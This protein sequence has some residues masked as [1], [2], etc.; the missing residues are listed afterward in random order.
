MFAAITARVS[1][2]NV[3]IGIYALVSFAAVAAIVMAPGTIG[4]HW[5]WMIPSDP[6]EL[7]RFALTDGS[8]WQDYD[9]GSY[10]TYRYA[11]VLTSLLFGLP[12]YLG[13]DGGFVTKSLVASGVFVSA[14]GMRYLLL[15]LTRD[16]ADERDGALA[17]LGGLL[18]A[19]APYAYNQIVAGDQSALIADALSPIAIALAVRCIAPRENRWLAF[20]LTAS[21]LLGII[22]ASVQVFVFTLAVMWAV[23]LAIGWS[24]LTVVRLGVLTAVSIALCAFWLLPAF[25]AGGAVH[26]VVQTSP[27]D[28]AIATFGQFSNPLLTLTM[29]AFPGDFYLRAIAQG[30]PLYFAAFVLLLALSVAAIAIRRTPLSIV[31]GVLFLVTA[32]VPLGGNAFIGPAI[33]AVFRALLPYSLFLRTPQHLMFVMALV[34]P[35]M[36]YLAARVVAPKYYTVSLVAGL[37]VVAAY[38]Q[39]FFLHSNYFGLIGPFGESNG[40]RATVARAAESDG[41]SYRTLFVPNSPSFYFHPGIFDYFFE[42]SDDPQVR[43]LPGMSLGAG[44]KWTPYDRTQHLVKALDELVPDGADSQTQAMLLKIAGIQQIVVHHIGTPTAGVRLATNNQQPYLESALRATRLATLEGAYDDRSIWRLGRAVPRVYAPDCVF[45]VP[46]QADPYD[47]LALAPAAASCARPVTLATTV[48]SERS[49]EIISPESFR[50]NRSPGVPF[51]L[52]PSNV[53]IESLDGG[54]AFSAVVPSRTQDVEIFELPRKP[55][56]ATGVSLRMYSSAPRRVYV[57]LYSPDEL[58]FLQATVD[59]SGPVQDVALNFRDFGHV[60][61]PDVRTFRY[62]RLA[63]INM[64]GHD[65]RMYVGDARWL[66]HSVRSAVPP[67]LTVS[68]NRWDGFYFGGNRDRVVYQPTGSPVPVFATAS[69]VRTGTYDVVAR[70]Q[71]AKRALSLR[72]V[73]DGRATRC[74][75]T[76]GRADETERLVRLARL[77]MSRGRHTIALAFCNNP[78]VSTTASGVQALIIAAA[79]FAPPAFRSGGTV[80]VASTAPGT[81]RLNVGSNVIVFT[82]SFDDRWTATQNGAALARVMANGYANAW[83]VPDPSAGD[84]VLQFWPQRSFEFGIAVSLGL[85]AACLVIIALTLLEFRPARAPAPVTEH[86]TQA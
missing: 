57:Q 44:Q 84:V 55:A 61:R 68:G 35:M 8:A 69:I 60:G 33:I 48:P 77:P 63:S 83:R 74:S 82:D 79:S 78:L 40:E 54:H 64:Q 11:T 70:V 15:S 45:G 23:C 42:G 30:A 85:A 24:R 21:L 58:N 46:P 62:V 16:D 26:T 10:V 50:I 37:F 1:R 75:P 81:M 3:A 47:V 4:H 22:V 31:L 65:V 34:V 41:D 56:A 86:A 66:Y 28:T 18:Y 49:E 53:A 25:L 67:Y 71:D 5:D 12:G 9:F 14:I 39:G 19:L 76:G 59:F 73:V 7:R 80:G 27:I 51:A 20:A 2:W 29:L 32:I 43:F 6:A 17:T 13:L 72:A 52:Q 36:V 38:G